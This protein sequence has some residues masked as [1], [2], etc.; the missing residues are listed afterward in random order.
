MRIYESR[1]H[2]NCFCPELDNEINNNVT[3]VY[4]LVGSRCFTRFCMR[5][6]LTSN[7]ATCLKFSSVTGDAL[8][9]VT[10]SADGSVAGSIGGGG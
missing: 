5:H 8:I 6:E 7:S 10:F 4:F 1:V 9:I 3:D 2:I